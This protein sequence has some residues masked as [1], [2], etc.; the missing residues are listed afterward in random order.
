M[1]PN[2]TRIQRIGAPIRTR[3]VIYTC[4]PVLSDIQT[5]GVKELRGA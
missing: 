1:V 2:N 4:L 5:A 3:S